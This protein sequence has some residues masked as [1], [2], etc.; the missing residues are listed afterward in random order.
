MIPRA[1]F[2]TEDAVTHQYRCA[3]G[4]SIMITKT[5]FAI[6]TALVVATSIMSTANAQ[7]RPVQPFTQAE[8]IWFD[9]ATGR[10]D[11]MPHQ[12]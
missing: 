9:L 10:D 12:R 11:G 3:I 7:Q 6:T 4:D 2:L 8:Q 1:R 5:L